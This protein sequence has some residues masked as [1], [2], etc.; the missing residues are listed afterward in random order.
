[1]N[2]DVYVLTRLNDAW[3]LGM[4]ELDVALPALVFGFFGLV[5]GTGLSLA[6]GAGI[7]LWLSWRVSKLK[8][9]QHPGY[10]KHWLYWYFP[11][12]GIVNNFKILPDSAV[13]EMVG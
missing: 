5:K 6:I 13:R 8:A 9:A 11:N 2:R 12:I 1:M 7:G 10:A 3:R 4:W